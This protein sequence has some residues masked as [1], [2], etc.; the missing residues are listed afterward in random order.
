M[1][2]TISSPGPGQDGLNKLFARHLPDVAPPRNQQSLYQPEMPLYT[3]AGT[4]IADSGSATPSHAVDR[5][6][7]LDFQ[8]LGGAVEGWM[9]RVASR[10]QAARE[11]QEQQRAARASVGTPGKGAGGVGD[12]IE[13][14]DEFEIGGEESDDDDTRGRVGGESSGYLAR[15][16][17]RQRE[18]RGDYFGK[19]GKAD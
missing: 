17:V 19:A 7:I 3:D 1:H 11:P 14:T 9:R 4:P 10:A 6:L 2:K 8:N 16:G 18:S 5:N 15:S 12:L 13:M